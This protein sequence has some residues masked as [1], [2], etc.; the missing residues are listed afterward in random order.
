MDK[1]YALSTQGNIPDMGEYAKQWQIL[2]M[3]CDKEGRSSTA[4]ICRDRAKHYCQI[5]GGE[6]VRL[7]EGCYAELIIVAQAERTAF[8]L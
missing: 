8:S 6:Y 7:V 4:K 1:Y 2:A 5:A 3:D